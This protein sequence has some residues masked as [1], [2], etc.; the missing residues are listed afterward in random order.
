MKAAVVYGPNDIRVEEHQKPQ[1]TQEDE[2]L[3]KVR[4]C[5]IC[6]SDVAILTGHN[7]FVTYPRVMGHEFVGEIEYVGS[8]VSGFSLGDHVVVEPIRFSGKSFACR[9]GMPNVSEDLSVNGVHIDGGMQEY[10]VVKDIQAHHIRNDIPWTTAVLCEPYTIGGNATMRAGVCAGDSVL[11][12]GSGAIG[13]CVARVAHAKGARVMC[14]DIVDDKLAFI[15]QSGADCVVN[16]QSENLEEAVRAWTQ[17]EMANVVIDVVGQP[18]TLQAALN[19]TSVAGSIVVLGM[20]DAPVEITQKPIMAKQLSIFGSRL[21]A[22]QFEPIIHLMEDGVLGDDGLVTHTF[23]LER[24]SDAFTLIYSH[25]PDVRK[26]VLV[27][28]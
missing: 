21:Q 20:S 15:Q 17:G 12:E 2:V 22:Y 24:V 11:I 27:M 1:I 4:A 6:G 10:I 8:A 5:G 16:T 14:T 26:V 19:L 23:P 28:P 9:R 25:V 13:T 3:I 7:A 18:A